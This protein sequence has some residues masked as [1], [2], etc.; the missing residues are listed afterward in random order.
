MKAANVTVEPYW[1]MLI[2]N[3]AQSEDLSKLIQNV[4]AAPATST[5]AAP[6]G[7]QKQE[8]KAEEKKEEKEEEKVEEEEDADMGLDLFGDD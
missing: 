7:E 6:T 2:S 5:G 4:G 1:P 3:Y 8:E